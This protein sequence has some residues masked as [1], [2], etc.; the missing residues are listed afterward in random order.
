MPADESASDSEHTHGENCPHCGH[1]A[2][3]TVDTMIDG[4]GST[5]TMA[6]V[7]CQRCGELW[8]EERDF[9]GVLPE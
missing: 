9:Y 3:E 4:F 2:T 5:V 7:E 8:G 1:F 6:V